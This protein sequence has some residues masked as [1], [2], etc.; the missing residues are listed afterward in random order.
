MDVSHGHY[1]KSLNLKNVGP[2]TSLLKTVDTL[3]RRNKYTEMVLLVCMMSFKLSEEKS[4]Y[5]Q[6]SQNN[7]LLQRL[8][9]WELTISFI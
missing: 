2:C 9:I 8:Q 4:M 7:S 6:H 3:T 1:V 5:L